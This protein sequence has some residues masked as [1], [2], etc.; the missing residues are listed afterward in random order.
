MRF[1]YAAGRVCGYGGYRE[2]SAVRT[3]QTRDSSADRRDQCWASSALCLLGK[4]R[5]PAGQTLNPLCDRRMG[6]EQAAEV[7]AE[8]WLN[9]K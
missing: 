7:H 2:H 9:N 3:R 8:E 4:F 5:R 1:Y 6:R